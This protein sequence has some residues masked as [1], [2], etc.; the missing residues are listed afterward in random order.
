[1]F[2]PPPLYLFP[3]LPPSPSGPSCMKVQTDAIT[4][5]DA[6]I[7]AANTRNR[8]RLHVRTDVANTAHSDSFVRGNL[9]T[10]LKGGKNGEKEQ[11]KRTVVAKVSHAEVMHRQRL[12]SFVYEEKREEEGGTD[13]VK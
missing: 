5:V 7:D 2:T 6:A 9:P 8:T 12:P 13:S 4:P 3:L 10:D 11:N 1:M